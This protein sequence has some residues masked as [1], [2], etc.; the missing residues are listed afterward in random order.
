[1]IS[2]IAYFL[3]SLDSPTISDDGDDFDIQLDIPDTA[4]L[5]SMTS[6]TASLSLSTVQRT[7]DVERIATRAGAPKGL[8]K[9]GSSMKELMRVPAPQAQ[10]ASVKPENSHHD[11]KAGDVSDTLLPPLSDAEKL[12]HEE[13]LDV[14]HPI[15]VPYASSRA[16]V[17]ATSSAKQPSRANVQTQVTS[18]VARPPS[19]ASVQAR[20]TSGA[21]QPPP[22]G[23]HAQAPPNEQPSAAAV[24]QLSSNTS[25]SGVEESQTSSTTQS[26]TQS[27]HGPASSSNARSQT[28]DEPLHEELLR[29]LSSP[30]MAGEADGEDAIPPTREVHVFRRNRAPQ[31]AAGAA[32][33]A[34]ESPNEERS[35]CKS[36]DVSHQ[37]PSHSSPRRSGTQAVVTNLPRAAANTASSKALPSPLPSPSD[38]KEHQG[39]ANS[40]S[41]SFKRHTASS[42]ISEKRSTSSHNRSALTPSSQSSRVANQH[43]KSRSHPTPTSAHGIPTSSSTSSSTSQTSSKPPQSSSERRRPNWNPRSSLQRSQQMDASANRTDAHSK[44]GSSSSRSAS[45]ERGARKRSRSLAQSDAPLPS[46]VKRLKTT[47]TRKCLSNFIDVSLYCIAP[48][49]RSV[50][51]F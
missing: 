14:P 13:A 29:Q 3:V 5:F 46:S 44:S 49:P 8:E 10:K 27:Q 33:H 24:S 32:A 16:Q 26:R 22:G 42:S 43:P 40:S 39:A 25:A 1:M 36:S 6:T 20:A 48:W 12:S 4:S 17:Q 51:M 11:L 50:V 35:N 38:A 30:V 37:A 41:S 23:T 34:H 9:A 18:T 28:S 19:T 47:R 21:V 7:T 31:P 45:S 2:K 15:D